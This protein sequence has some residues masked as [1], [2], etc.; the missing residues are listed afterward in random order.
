MPSYQCD[1][2]LIQRGVVQL[3]L[4]LVEPFVQG[5]EIDRRRDGLAQA[6]VGRGAL[7]GGHLTVGLAGADRRRL[8]TRARHLDAVVHDHRLAGRQDVLVAVEPGVLG[9]GDDA[10]VAQERH[11]HRSGLQRLVGLG[12]ADDRHEDQLIEVHVAAQ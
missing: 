10:G 3:V 4:A 12:L 1:F 5:V 9:V 2:G 11:L 7:G 6:L 8:T